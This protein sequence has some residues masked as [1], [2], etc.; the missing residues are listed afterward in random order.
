MN[1]LLNDDTD[2][3]ADGAPNNLIDDE[4]DE[5]SGAESTQV[6]QKENRF[7][8]SARRKIEDYLE[9]KRLAAMTRDFL[10]DD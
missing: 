6:T 5:L 10:F 1:T 4:R 8:L 2:T 3:D 7:D 9:R